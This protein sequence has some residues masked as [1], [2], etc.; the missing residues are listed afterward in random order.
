LRLRF[1]WRAAILSPTIFGIFLS[2]GE[3]EA[4]RLM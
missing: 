4:A 3:A 2:I 1:E